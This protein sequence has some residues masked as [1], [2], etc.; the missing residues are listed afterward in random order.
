M[1][2]Q[3]CTL[4]LP[5]LL[6]KYFY[7]VPWGWIVPEAVESGVMLTVATSTLELLLVMHKSLVSC[8]QISVS[9]MKEL[10]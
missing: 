9:R 4:L 7:I 1:P 3:G 8:L 10:R 2:V 6:K 5:L